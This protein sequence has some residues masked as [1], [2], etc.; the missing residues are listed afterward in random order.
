MGLFIWQGLQIQETLN[1]VSISVSTASVIYGFGDLLA[2]HVNLHEARAPLLY[3]VLG[4]LATFTDTLLRAF[5]M[6]YLFSIF[7]GFAWLVLP[8]YICL[9]LIGICL[10][11]GKMSIEKLDFFGTLTSFSCSAGETKHTS[12]N[13]RPISKVVFALIFV[14][15]M[16]LLVYS[17]S[18]MPDIGIGQILNSTTLASLSHEDCLSLCNKS[19][20]TKT[21]CGSLWRYLG[22]ETTFDVYV[23]NSETMLSIPQTHG[24]ILI[25]LS[26]LF[27]LSILEGLLEICISCMP[28]NYLMQQHIRYEK[29][30][31]VFAYP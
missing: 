27:I 14:P 26:V 8:T 2:Y 16:V 7:K 29:N 1:Y 3:T 22:N 19:E 28:Y 10:R 21:Y 31:S 6:A 9:M 4:M 5:F 25:V 30:Y 15:C 23:P 20:T 17:V 18:F 11:K 24:I 13:L 12:Y